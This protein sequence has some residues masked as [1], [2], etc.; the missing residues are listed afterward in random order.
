[1]CAG[2]SQILD[3]H[4]YA[5]DCESNPPA[6]SEITIPTGGGFTGWNIEM[7]KEDIL[8]IEQRNLTYKQNIASIPSVKNEASARMRL[9]LLVELPEV[10]TEFL[11]R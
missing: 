1:M 5:S 9:N 3:R 11:V 4:I 6:I 7:L 10:C 2:T 8:L